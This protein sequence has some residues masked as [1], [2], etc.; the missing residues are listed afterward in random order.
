MDSF[1]CFDELVPLFSNNKQE[2]QELVRNGNAWI[3]LW[4]DL[5]PCRAR[6]IS[7]MLWT[8]LCV[9]FPQHN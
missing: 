7:T 6:M 3:P 4:F 1:I 9:L 5:C 2:S 8:V